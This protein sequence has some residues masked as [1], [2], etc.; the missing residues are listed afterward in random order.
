M[1]E[2]AYMGLMLAMAGVLA[3]TI[4]KV[5]DYFDDGDGL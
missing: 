5:M 4:I 1:M 2:Y 3:F